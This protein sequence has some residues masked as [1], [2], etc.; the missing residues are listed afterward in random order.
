MSADLNNP[1]HA[2][3]IFGSCNSQHFEQPFWDVVLKR[4]PTAFVWAGD[5]LYAD[6][7]KHND[8]RIMDANPEYLRQLYQA[9]RA[10]PGYKQLIDTANSGVSIFGT[11]DDHDYGTNNGDRTFSWKRENAIEFIKFLGLDGSTAMARRASQGKGVYG[12]QVY[13]FSR[14]PSQKRRLSDVEAAL[15]PDVITADEFR[16]RRDHEG[17]VQRTVAVFVLDVRTHKTPWSSVFSERFSTYPEGDFLGEEQWTW[18]ETALGRSN[19]AVNVIVSG[20][21]I[22]APWFY[23]GNLVENWSAFPKAQHRLYQAVLQANVAAPLLIS[24]DVH[25]AQLLRKD[26]KKSVVE[27][28]RMTTIRPLYEITTSGMTH[29]WGSSGASICGR[30]NLNRLCRFYP[31][32]ALFGGIMTFAHWISPWTALLRDERT[33]LPQY[34]LDRNIAEVDLDWNRRIVTVRILG[35]EGHTLLR[36]DWSMDKLSEGSPE[37]SS[38]LGTKS[39]EVARDRLQSSIHPTIPANDYICVN[40]RGNPDPVHFAFSIAAVVS[41]ALV[42]SLYPFLFAVGLFIFACGRRRRKK[43]E[44][45]KGAKI[46]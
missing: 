37:S 9:Q 40:Y 35:D 20:V 26:C 18:F 6:D 30:P 28:D 45:R 32:N 7:R 34:S 10:V 22:H 23:D 33:N 5:S 24:G 46:D 39:F 8:G 44:I 11:I 36:Q 17:D 16:S 29:S 25:L 31:Y 1:H 27:G 42:S 3:I 21:Q 38:L 43:Q 15:D 12:V 2:R 14:H 41:F 13:D 19:A 4:L